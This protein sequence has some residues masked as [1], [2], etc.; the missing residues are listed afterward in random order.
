MK[1][2]IIMPTYNERENL[3][4]IIP[5]IM[6]AAPWANVLV[7]DDN[8]PDGTGQLADE[9]AAHDSRIKVLHRPG[10][11]GLGTAYI[12]GFKMAIA[13]GFDR[14][15]EMDADFSH[16]PKYLPAL[17]RASED[18]DLVIG[19]RYI[20]GGS[21]PNWSAMRRFISGGGNTFARTMLGIRVHDCTAG[22][23]CYHRTA[24]E[25]LD[26]DSIR[27]Q[28]Y[29][30]Q[31]ELVYQ[32]LRQRLRVKEIPI[33][34]VDRRV[35]QSKMSRGIFVEGFQFVIRTLRRTGRAPRPSK[36]QI[37]VATPAFVAES[38]GSGTA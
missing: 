7:V 18:A 30:F 28:G 33:T 11:Q 27:S 32:V 36:G 38:I 6:Q 4:E 16:D 9:M 2:V 34:F 35:G 26:L 3:A 15:F 5:A 17:L 23:R 20:P 29:S 8:S 1:S 24:L 21:T 19:S 31:V 10:K 25:A 37:T 12:Q 22:F 14:I 13:H